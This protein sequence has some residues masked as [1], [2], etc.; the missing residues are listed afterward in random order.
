MTFL[1]IADLYQALNLDAQDIKEIK[2][3]EKDKI[4]ISWQD[5]LSQVFKTSKPVKLIYEN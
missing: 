1:K 3:I 2:Q 5:G 4:E